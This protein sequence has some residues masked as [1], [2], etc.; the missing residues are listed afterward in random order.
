MDS[1]FNGPYFD[2]VM[3]QEPLCGAEYFEH[4]SSAMLFHREGKLYRL[5]TDGCGHNFLSQQSAVGNRLVVRVIQDFGPMAPNDDRVRDEF[6][7][8]SEVEWLEPVLPESAEGAFLEKLFKGLTG[9]DLV[10][11]HERE[12]FLDR[13]TI[14]AS[15][16]KE[17]SG[18]L[19]T[20]IAAAQYLPVNDGTV[21]A[22]ITNI[23]R[24]P[25]TDEIVWSDPMHFA[26][27]CL[28]EAQIAEMDRVREQVNPQ[29]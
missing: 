23:M 18:L 25:S 13:C 6:Y 17:Y 8:L 19:S 29:K 14:A 10:D 9:G 12:R 28:T 16:H 11:H 27:G 24:R 7:W 3:S 1:L 21:D 26:L 20:L 15:T 5:T 22:N 4:G 2:Y